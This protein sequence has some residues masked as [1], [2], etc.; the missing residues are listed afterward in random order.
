MSEVTF[1]EYSILLTRV[2]DLIQP[3]PGPVIHVD[4]ILIIEMNAWN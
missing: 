3:Y 1:R 2:P 4:K